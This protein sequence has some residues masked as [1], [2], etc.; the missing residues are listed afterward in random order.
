MAYDVQEVDAPRLTGMGLKAFTWLV[1]QRRLGALLR[2]IMS[3]QVGLDRLRTDPAAGCA[4]I[5]KPWYDRPD[6]PARPAQTTSAAAQAEVAASLEAPAAMP[7]PTIADYA[8]AY[9]DGSAS[10]VD[11]ARRFLSAVEAED[12]ASPP[13]RAFIAVDEADLLRQAEDSAARIAAGEARSILEGVPIA[14]KDEVDMVPFPTTVGTAFLGK[15]PATGDATTVARIRA[16]GALLLGKANMHELGLGVTGLN[17]HHGPPRNPYGPGHCTGGSSS[18]SAA[19]VAAGL[20]PVALGADGGGSIR[21][22]AGLCGVVGLKPTFGRV[23]EHGAAPLCWSVAHI[24]P[25]GQTARDTAALYALMAG[26][27]PADPGTRFQPDPHLEGIDRTDLEGLRF[28][29]Y[30]P[31]L[32]HAEP[33]VVARC[34]EAIGAME[35]LGAEIVDVEIEGL[36]DL[37]VAHLVVIASEMA[38]ARIGE[39]RA[40]RLQMGLDVR[41]N[42]ALASELSATDYVQALRLRERITAELEGLLDR[43]HGLLTPATGTPA[44]PIRPDVLSAGESDLPTLDR[45]MR[46]APGPNLTGHP[47]ISFP[48]GYDDESGLPIGLQVIGR[49]WQEPLLLGIAHAMEG[50]VE[51]RPPVRMAQLLAG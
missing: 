31:W 44:P 12:A 18:G 35:G 8:A 4:P 34:Y 9:R 25:I 22:P 16:S 13:L 45:I 23:S 11:V 32:E 50:A 37:R 42:F 19:A 1:E 48:I 43:V 47:A 3:K 26:I 49:A 5:R 46:F 41:L 30:R 51:R 39:S 6:D 40:I 38:A 28:G 24:G 29:V 33:A 36:E 21:I 14:I 20:C 10:P 17:L 27:D 2:G 7:H 15:T